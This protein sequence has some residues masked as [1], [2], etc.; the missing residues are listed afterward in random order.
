MFKSINPFTGQVIATFQE[1]TIQKVNEI[2][3]KTDL[4]FQNWR[5]V[6]LTDRSLL[7]SRLANILEKEKEKLGRLITLEM[8]KLIGESHAEI[9]KCAWLCKYYA[10]NAEEM[11]K[12][13]ILPSD[14]SESYVRFDPTGV[15]YAI[16]PWNF[17]LWQ[18]LRFAV[19]TIMAGNTMVL[20]H[21]PNVFGCAQAIEQLFIEAGF[22]L[23]VFSNLI[24]PTTISENVIANPKIQGVTITGSQKAGSI[25]A[26]QAGKYLKK[27]VLEL[28]GSDPCIIFSDADFNTACKI[29]T[30]SRMMN[31]GQV[32]ISAKRFIVEQSIFDQFVEEQK[33]LLES[34][35]PGDPL[36]PETNM[37]PLARKDLLRSIDK[38]V[39]KSVKM[40][41]KLIT[42]GHQ[43]ASTNFY[44]PTLLTNVKKGM[45]VYDEETFGPVSTVIPFNNVE[46]AITIANDTQFGLGASIW[47]QDIELADKMAAQIEAGAVFINGMTKSDPRLPFGGTKQSGYGRE[48]SHFG[49]REFANIKTVWIK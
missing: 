5:M 44:A 28:G 33:V 15:I 41:A 29:G 11:L 8:G 23:H 19:P 1:S 18:V 26:A 35:K 31:S 47:T 42:G 17:P 14:G 43:I 21:S 34:L 39:Q 45:P 10:E 3:I 27:S 20:K 30:T 32:C 9:E 24:I 25:V 16:M 48:L 12:P 6:K 49:I 40:G 37:A 13:E 22:P 46:E 2:I 38:Q 4:A 36:S 7:M